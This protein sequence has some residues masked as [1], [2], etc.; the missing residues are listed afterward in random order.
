[1]FRVLFAS[2]RTHRVRLVMTALA[3]ALSLIHI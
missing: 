3:V 2:L 1:M